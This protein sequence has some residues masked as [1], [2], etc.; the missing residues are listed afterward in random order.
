MFKMIKLLLYKR[1]SKKLK[2][3]RRELLINSLINYSNNMN[4]NV[5][6]VLEVLKKLIT[7][8]YITESLDKKVIV[9]YRDDL[10]TVNNFITDNNLEYL[11]NTDFYIENTT[12]IKSYLERE[13]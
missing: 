10:E 6:Y 7:Q 11:F 13:N 8:D 4:E 5:E 3:K 2:E 9:Q 1:K 12:F